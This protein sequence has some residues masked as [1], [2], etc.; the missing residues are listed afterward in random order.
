M[1]GKK[2]RVAVGRADRADTLRGRDGW[3]VVGG[4]GR[5]EMASAGGRAALPLPPPAELV[6]MPRPLI[7]P[8]R[9]W[10]ARLGWPPAVPSLLARLLT[11]RRP[12]RGGPQGGGCRRA[13]TP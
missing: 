6:L 2:T 4:E 3:T 10:I 1:G 13:K 8:Q 9:R 12:G 5:L 7:N 11:R